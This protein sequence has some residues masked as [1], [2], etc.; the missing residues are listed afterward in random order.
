MT[1]LALIRNYDRFQLPDFRK[2]VLCS[3]A[4]VGQDA[5]KQSARE[6]LG[7][8]SFNLILS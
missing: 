1:G 4:P 2:D 3:L 8:P 6:L 5:A 7:A